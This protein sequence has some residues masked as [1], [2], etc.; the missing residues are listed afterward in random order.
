VVVVGDL[1]DAWAPKC[2]ERGCSE[3]AVRRA[4]R[5]LVFVRPDTVVMDDDVEVAEGGTGVTWAAHVAVAPSIAPPRVVASVGQ[6]RLDLVALAPAR[7]ALRA[8]AEPTTQDEHIYKANRPDGAVWRIEIETPR[9]DPHRRVRVWMRAASA[10]AAPPEVVPIAGSGLGGAVGPVGAAGR[11]AVLFAEAGASRGE[12]ILPGGVARAV[13]VGLE[14]GAGYE[15]AVRP[16]AGAAAGCQL[17]LA[18][19]AARSGAAKADEA[20]AIAVDLARCS[21]R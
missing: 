15:V 5:T 20:G 17:A 11:V 2:V 9:G 18:A 6:S 7:A 12:V 4:I 21:R 16:S 3:R 1:A 13:V 8:P 14:A 19:G 10:G